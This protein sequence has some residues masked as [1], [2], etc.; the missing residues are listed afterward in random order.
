MMVFNLGICWELSFISV[1]TQRWFASSVSLLERK[2]SPLALILTDQFNSVYARG[3]AVKGR[4][5][6]TFISNTT[7]RLGP[8]LMW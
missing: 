2:D 5:C 7:L 4:L 3:F 6:P 1:M 8:A